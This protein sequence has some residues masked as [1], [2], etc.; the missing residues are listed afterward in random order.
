[1]S[2]IGLYSL[3]FALIV[4]LLGIGVGLYAGLTRRDAWTRVAE[5]TVY[6]VFGFLSLAMFAL[7]YALASND[8]QLSYVARH[9]A[10]SMSLLY[11]LS[12]AWGGQAG[13]LLLW[14]FLLTGYAAAAVWRHRNSSR[15]L[16]PWVVVVVL[17]NALFFLMLT[18]FVDIPF[19]KLPSEQVLSDGIGLNPLLQHPMM[20]THPVA[21]YAGFVGFAIPFAFSFAALITGE[22][23]TTWFRTTRRW[24]LF[25]WT[26]LGIGLILGG[27]WAYD[28]LGWGG[29]WGWDPVENAALMPWLA[30]T[31][32][33]HSVMI[34][35]KRDMLK[36]WNVVL[37]GLTYT[38]CLFGTF[39]TRS[40]VV[41]SVH[42][43]ANS[44]WFGS[45]FGAYMVLMAGAF[46]SA[47]VVRRKQLMS[48]RRLES[49]ASREA[50]FLLN[51]WAFMALLMVVFWGT[52]LPVF[53]ESLGGQ[54]ITVGP[55]FF[56][57]MAGPLALFLLFLTGAGPLIAWR[58]AT[59]ANLRRQFVW[60]GVAAV[61]VGVGAGAWGGGSIGFWP[62][63]CW[64]LSAFVSMT[65]AQ[66]YWRAIG[67]RVR[68][69]GENVLRA[70][71]SLLRK[72]PR[73]YG[74]YIVHLGAVLMMVGFSGA[75]FNEE[76]LKN[77]R[78]GQSVQMR[79][80]RLEYLTTT[81]ITAQHYGGA[82]ARV[83]LYRDDAPLGVMVPEKRMYWL[84]DQPTS[85]P[86]IHSRLSED[87]YLTLTALEAD[88]SVTLKIHRNPLVNWVWIGSII[89]VAGCLCVLWPQPERGMEPA[90]R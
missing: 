41:Q 43:F 54:R 50:G 65:I 13:S 44:G 69:R 71:A 25:A 33:L 67:A 4:A 9:S 12:A 28:V 16:M 84:E 63:A 38:L 86:A 82:R 21:L 46:A 24:S 23:D 55:K 59:A 36:T 66:E 15:S 56:N 14:E 73:R 30:A 60:P 40:G 34:Q 78:V 57:T 74:G 17:V 2:D 32:Y 83:A 1:L 31:A 37:I 45:L 77:V 62:L 42:A 35:E 10:R 6:V 58:R 64:V 75:A 51:N 3:R 22:L 29:Y 20:T 27:R 79:D 5:R 18:N 88:G 76:M 7:F 81:A 61:A 11:R 19:D 87:L 48:S 8:F 90:R 68:N 52:M 47:V 85:I 80:Y 39:L 89:L 53:S 72:N 26:M 70:L 49:V